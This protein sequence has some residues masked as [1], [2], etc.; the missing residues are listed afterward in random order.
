[1]ELAALEGR[2]LRRTAEP[3]ATTA[4]RHSPKAVDSALRAQL[5]NSLLQARSPGSAWLLLSS[6]RAAVVV[7]KSLANSASQESLPRELAKRASQERALEQAESFPPLSR[8]TNA[9]GR[10]SSQ[11]LFTTS[12]DGPL[13][14][15]RFGHCAG[16]ASCFR[17]WHALYLSRFSRTK[18]A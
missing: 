4:E 12:W 13:R 5:A 16:H 6:Q 8:V 7:S 15:T 1:M 3:E 10:S 18:V 2:R 9:K 17:E 11:S 14:Q